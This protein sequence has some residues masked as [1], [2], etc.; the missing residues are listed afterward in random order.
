MWTNGCFDLLHNGHIHNL[1]EAKQQ[2]DVL[3]VGV[4]SDRSVREIKGHGRPVIDEAA[5][6]Q[7][8]AALECVDYV[9]LFNEDTPI[10]AITGLQPDV[11]CKG[12]DYADN[13]KP[14]PERA[15]VEKYGGRIHFLTLVPG[16]STTGIIDRIRRTPLTG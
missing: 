9:T 1:I 16:V 14:I 15:T 6:L 2:G 12:S 10:A 5:R 11:H 13:A 8:L 4:N 3:V 7:M